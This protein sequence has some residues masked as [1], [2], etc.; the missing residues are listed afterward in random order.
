MS[1]STETIAV[2]TLGQIFFLL[3][4]AKIGY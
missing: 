3:C 4:P 1:N 2:R